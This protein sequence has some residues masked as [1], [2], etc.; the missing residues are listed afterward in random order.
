VSLLG[1]DV[2]TTGCKA[3]AF[4]VEGA[5]LAEAYREYETLHPAP[6]QA[7]LDAR[8]VWARVS[9]AIAEAASGT[10]S[11]PVSALCVS[12][13]G[14]AMVPLT[15]D[16]EILGNCILQVDSRGAEYV[17]RLRDAFESEG[18]YAINPNVLGPSYSLPK[19]MWLRDHEPDLYRRADHFLLWGEMVGFMLGCEPVTSYSH[20]NRT[21]LFDIHREDWSERLLEWAGIDRG[22]L[23]RTAPSGTVVGTLG[24]DAASRAQLPTGT[25]VVVGGHDQCCNS[26]GAGICSAG[27]AVCGIGTVECITPTYDRIPPV[28]AMLARGLNVEHHVLGD[29]YVSFLY[30]QGGSLVKW[31]RD[32][33]AAGQRGVGDTGSVYDLLTAEMPAEPTRLL[34]LPY[35]E[36]TG[37]P[38][39][40]SDA[41]GAIIGLTTS[42]TRGEILKSIL[43]CET[44]YFVDSVQ[45]LADVGIDTSR[46]VATGGG[47]KSDAWLQIKADVFGVPFVRNQVTEAGMLG[48]AML[49]GIATG[50]FGTASEAAER[51]VQEQRIFEPDD[52][53][54]RAYQ[55]KLESYRLLLPTLRDLLQRL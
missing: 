20:A 19:L 27:A 9:E 34:T 41:A 28:E 11:D 26:L 52:R 37:P 53:R 16:R 24:P 40:V 5:C 36:M 6:G 7:E 2:G 51:F 43:E 13:M 10:R 23:A 8:Q 32:T 35:F 47:A 48:A 46:F 22:K 1:V 21:L 29:L 45:A 30:N 4:S 55:D 50:E 12:S 3:A 54:H 18:F 42:T 33:F 49:A 31:F 25:A 17:D 14:E 39:F 15:A 44:L 38:E